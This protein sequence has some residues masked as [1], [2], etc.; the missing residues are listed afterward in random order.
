MSYANAIGDKSYREIYNKSISKD[1]GRKV[2]GEQ[3]EF[4]KA[5]FT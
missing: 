2:L 4:R 1:F 3:L 5:T